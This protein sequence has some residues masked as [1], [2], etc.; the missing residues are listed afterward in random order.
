MK[1]ARYLAARAIDPTVA[2]SLGV[3]IRGD[4][5]VF[6]NG[7]RRRFGEGAKILGAKGQPLRGWWLQ[8]AARRDALVCEGEADALAAVCAL[9]QAPQVTGLSDLPVLCVPGTAYPLERLAGDLARVDTAYLA[10]DPDEAGALYERKVIAR[11]VADGKRP[12]PLNLI[13]SDG[14]L[15]GW[16]AKRARRERADAF[17]SLLIDAEASAPSREGWMRRRRIAELRDE[18]A[19]LE[20]A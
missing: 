20:A 19:R 11:L 15:A 10:F 4:L 13:A 17:A 12:V 5:I 16:I 3:K 18:L 14:D 7:R 6:P 1:I 2:T 8:R 9:R